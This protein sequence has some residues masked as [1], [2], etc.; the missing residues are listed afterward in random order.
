MLLYAAGGKH[1]TTLGWPVP[2][3]EPVAQ[4]LVFSLLVVMLY[5]TDDELS[6]RVRAPGEK[7]AL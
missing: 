7:L 5:V 1:L 3:E 4:L 6:S 2:A